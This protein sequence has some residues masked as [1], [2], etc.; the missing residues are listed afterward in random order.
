M[1]CSCSL[2]SHGESSVA[3]ST[4]TKFLHKSSST[5]KSG[6][7]RLKSPRKS[8]LSSTCSTRGRVVCDISDYIGGDLLRF[9][10]GKFYKDVEKF[11]SIAIY[12][13]PEGGYEGRYANKLQME[14][15]H[16]MAMSAKGLG[17]LES[18]LTKVHGVRPPHLGKQ[19]ISVWYFPPEIDYRLSMLPEDCKGL[20]LWLLECEVLSKAELQFL[21]LLPALRPKV[22]VIAECGGWRKFVWTPLKNI[23][24][25]SV[26]DES[27]VSKEISKPLVL[28]PEQG[29]DLVAPD[30]SRSS[31]EA[32]A[33]E[34]Q[35]AN[36]LSS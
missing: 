14:G 9:D 29:K 35:E 16:I 34:Q 36:T 27:Q 23:A 31:P 4:T 8:G 28:V 25:T 21:T 12:P 33:Q 1:S 6:W 17:D 5:T 18:Y 10:R 20:V 19:A 13:P 30:S 15:Y 2:T 11:G 22:R 3:A 7:T 26:P 24:G 32:S